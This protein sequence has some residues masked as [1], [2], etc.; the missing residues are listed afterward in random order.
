MSHV[1]IMVLGQQYLLK[2]IVLLGSASTVSENGLCA[3]DVFFILKTV[4]DAYFLTFFL[5]GNKYSIFT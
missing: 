5:L 4:S 3:L 2:E 1:R